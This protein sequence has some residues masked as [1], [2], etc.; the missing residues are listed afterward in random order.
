HRAAGFAE[1]VRYA[2]AGPP[3]APG[4]DVPQTSFSPCVDVE[5]RTQQHRPEAKLEGHGNYYILP[6]AGAPVEDQD[7]VVLGGKKY[8]VEEPYEEAGF[9]ACRATDAP[10][11]RHNVVY[12]RLM[13]ESYV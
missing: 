12:R 6:P 2:P 7:Y 10:D 3:E 1:I 13:G 11:T 4:G 5:L 8:Y 9:L